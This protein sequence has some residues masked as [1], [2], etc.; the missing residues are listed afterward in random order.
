MMRIDKIDP[1]SWFVGMYENH[2][3]LFVYGDNLN[4]ITVDATFAENSM[5]VASRK[6]F[7]IANLA[8][9]GN[10]QEGTYDI[11]FRRGEECAVKAYSLRTRQTIEHH[12][13]SPADV[14]Y[15]IMPDRFARTKDDKV[16]DDVDINNPHAWH[17][18]TL[19]GIRKHLDYIHD[20][21]VT[22][23]WLTPVFWN[24]HSLYKGQY[25]SYHGYA[26]TDFYEIDPHFGTLED[27]KALVD[28]AHC[29]G[30]KVV[31]D[32]VFNHCGS[33]HPWVCRGG[34]PATWINQNVGKTNYE[35][36]T[37]L[38]PY[39]SN[40]DREI[41]IKGYFSEIMKDLNLEDENVLQ[42]L[43][44][45]TFWWIEVT[46]IDA[47]RM[48]T[49][50]YSEGKQMNK[51]LKVLKEQYPHFSV[52]AET[53]MGN[54]ALTAKVQKDAL[55]YTGK[56]NPLIVMDF[57]FQES[58]SK[59]ISIG[60]MRPLYEH[61]VCDF[62]YKSPQQALAFLDNHDMLRWRLEHPNI[63]KMKQA[64][65][66]L[67]TTPRI[68]QI[69]YGTEYL[70]A[71]GGNGESDGDMRQDFAWSKQR[72]SEENA[73][74]NFMH[75][76]LHWRKSCLAVTQGTMTHFLPQRGVYVYFRKYYKNEVMII[77]NPQ[78]AKRKITLK[79][80]AEKLKG[81]RIATDIITGSEYDLSGSQEMGKT[82]LEIQKYGILILTLN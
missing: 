70:F 72:T 63:D 6:H 2:L 51:W 36:R 30:L 54:P 20:L 4:G 26:I 31:M 59:A 1:P 52:I 39:A 41:T 69:L 19:N 80:Y 29:R 22:T 76:L 32:I 65:A 38:D 46:G 17:G 49:Y 68:P 40:Y 62:L 74:Y 5:V 47:F 45:M 9:K 57:A 81:S 21:G 43:T 73:F 44:Q 8:L 15:L 75:H 18:G 78:K 3:Q 23:I 35:C 27:Y 50:L 16:Y 13:L 25:A 79:R 14:V 55:P 82:Y 77:V 12:A 48:D 11:C 24:N 7:A 10:I 56:E 60:D 67:L 33:E 42:Y 28:E 64:L 37:V 61:L 71:G 34:A 66:I 53:W 58:L